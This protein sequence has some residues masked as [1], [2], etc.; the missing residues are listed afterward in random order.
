MPRRLR[1]L[2]A[3]GLAL[4]L[5]LGGC[6][7][8]QEQYEASPATVEEGALAEAGYEA[9]SA[10]RISR[11]RTDVRGTD[12]NVTVV[13]YVRSYG[14]EVSIAGESRRLAAAV[15]LST[16]SIVVANREFNPIADESPSGLLD[17]FQ[18]RLGDRFGGDI[19]EISRLG[20]RSATVLGTET[21]VS[22]FRA[23]TTVDGRDVP[24]VIEITRVKH[25]ND[26]VV[27][28]GAYPERLADAEQS[29]VE[30]LLAGLVHATDTDSSSGT[31]A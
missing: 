27:V 6:V 29:R 12:D 13:S 3:V 5:V 10:D 20:A 11:T 30:T 4:A 24:V 8:V 21:N 25:E 26:F 2:G 14:R 16:P 9:A 15:T 23:V 19:G 1:R 28:A 17:R 31:D 7:S 22:R 18:G